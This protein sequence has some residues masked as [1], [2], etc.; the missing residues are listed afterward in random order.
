MANGKIIELLYL[1]GAKDSFIVEKFQRQ[2]F[3]DVIKGVFLGYSFFIISW[4]PFY[5]LAKK[6]SLDLFFHSASFFVPWYFI[7]L[8]PIIFIFISQLVVKRSV[9]KRV[10]RIF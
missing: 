3:K 5:F 6:F 1:F 4:L 10:Q 8:F 9:L 7:F 2:N